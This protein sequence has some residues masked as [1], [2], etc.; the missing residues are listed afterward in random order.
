MKTAAVIIRP[1]AVFQMPG[2]IL[3]GHVIV[4]P[5]VIPFGNEF[6]L[7]LADGRVKKIVLLTEITT[8]PE[9]WRRNLH[10][11]TYSGDVIEEEDLTGDAL[12]SNL[13]YDEA[14]RIYYNHAGDK[15]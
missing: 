9:A 15:L 14:L 11:F 5:Q 8:S 6:Q 2:R 12:V 10:G 7:Y 4:A 3:A 1:T 13:P